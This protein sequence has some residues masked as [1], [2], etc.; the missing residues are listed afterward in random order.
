MDGQHQSNTFKKACKAHT[1]HLKVTRLLASVEI[2]M[3]NIL[4]MINM[5]LLPSLQQPLEKHMRLKMA[6]PGQP[7]EVSTSGAEC[8]VQES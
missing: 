5:L 3:E 6:R 4:E 7:G 1:G 8:I 2:L